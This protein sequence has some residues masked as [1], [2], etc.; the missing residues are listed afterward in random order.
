M[1]STAEVTVLSLGMDSFEDWNLF[2]KV[3][4]F[5]HQFKAVG[6]RDYTRPLRITI[7]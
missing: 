2:S 7:Q 1:E 3:Q 6:T 4:P 5:Y